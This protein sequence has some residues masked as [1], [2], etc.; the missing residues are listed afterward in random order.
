MTRSLVALAL[1]L[2]ALVSGCGA[3]ALER[4]TQAAGAL[5]A[6]A[7]GG[8]GLIERSARFSGERALE[9]CQEAGEVTDCTHRVNE[10]VERYRPA[11]HA[12]NLFAA[13]VEAYI[14][15]VLAAAQEDK[16]DWSDALRLL[17]VAL[18]L[19]DELREAM[20]ALG[21]DLP[22]AGA[23]VRGAMGAF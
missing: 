2:A 8:A 13:T 7:D 12:Q 17:G 14:E 5:H 16:P 9:R 23:L 18:S 15:A 1:A 21:V 10:A 3:S 6:L 19:Y 11:E 22:D 4:H 20:A